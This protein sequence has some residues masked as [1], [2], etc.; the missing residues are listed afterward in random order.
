M[1]NSDG[2]DNHNITPDHFPPEFLCHQA[3]FTADD[4]AVLFIGEWYG[5]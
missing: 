2:S 4:S 3:V 5:G 1:M